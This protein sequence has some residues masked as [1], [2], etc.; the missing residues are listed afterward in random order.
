[1]GAWVVYFTAVGWGRHVT[2]PPS[3]QTKAVKEVRVWDGERQGQMFSL[4]T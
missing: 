3:P 1:M 4:F 2:L